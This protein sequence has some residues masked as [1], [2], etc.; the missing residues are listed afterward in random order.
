MSHELRAPAASIEAAR[1]LWIKARGHELSKADEAF[2]TE[3][4]AQCATL[5]AMVD[6]ALETIRLE[7]GRWQAHPE[8]VDLLD[9]LGEVESMVRPA[10]EAKGID[11][12]LKMPSGDVPFVRT[13]WDS[14]LRIISNLA[15]NAVKFTPAG[16]AVSMGADFDD[17]RSM[18]RISVCDTG[19]GIAAQDQQRV[20]ERFVQLDSSLAR[21]NH[22]SGLGLSLA[23]ELAGRIGASIALESEVGC[24]SVFSV[25]L[26]FAWNP[27]LDTKREGEDVEGSGC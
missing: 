8:V 10:A 27:Q 22:G 21:E 16:G 25:Y 24:G 18:A 2:S 9:V 3:V 4:D 1:S 26:P 6:N 12:S 19:V 13:D 11:L 17:K 20:F 23:V 5:L 14:L 15:N 7:Q